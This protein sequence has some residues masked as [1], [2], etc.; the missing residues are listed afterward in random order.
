MPS[1]LPPKSSF[2][3]LGLTCGEVCRESCS[4]SSDELHPSTK[5]REIGLALTSDY[6]ALLGGFN[7]I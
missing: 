6:A 3:C 5:S 2:G 7:Q 4:I 1:P